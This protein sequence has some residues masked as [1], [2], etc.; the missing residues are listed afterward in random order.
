MASEALK[1]KLA[2]E[3]GT[4]RWEELQR[5]FA[6]GMVVVVSPR[7]ALLDVAQ[8]MARDEKTTL[9]VWLEEG[10]VTRANDEHARGW[11]MTRP[12]LL[13]VVVAPWVVVQERAHG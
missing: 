9:A 8:A 10:L 3:I 1:Q 13:A 7:L 2:A 11:Q 12:E 5:H 4:L 6:R